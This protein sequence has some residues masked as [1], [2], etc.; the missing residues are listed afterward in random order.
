MTHMIRKQVYIPRRQQ[1]L[2]K[3]LAR[4]RGVSEAE[5]IR[6]A[7]EQQT[8][9]QPSTAL[10]HRAWDEALQ[11]MLAL[12]ARGPLNDQLR[13]WKREDA[14]EERLNRHDAYPG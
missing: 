4:A 7:I 2:L 9:N 6:Q 10:D 5:I 3:R 14:Y 8:S 13:Q 12:R 1:V 11:F